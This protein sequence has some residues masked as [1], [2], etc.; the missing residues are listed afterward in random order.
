MVAFGSEEILKP[1]QIPIRQL[2]FNWLLEIKIWCFDGLNRDFAWP[3]T[4]NY[5]EVA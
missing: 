3:I 4:G 1:D 5:R 2:I